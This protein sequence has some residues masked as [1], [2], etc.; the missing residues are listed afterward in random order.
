MT[1]DDTEATTAAISDIKI[2]NKGNEKISIQTIKRHTDT[3]NQSPKQ[4]YNIQAAQNGHQYVINVLSYFCH[5][6]LF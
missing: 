4:D 2:D 1:N 3:P 5:V 6:Y